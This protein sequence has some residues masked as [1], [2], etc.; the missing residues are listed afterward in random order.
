MYVGDKE[1]ERYAGACDTARITEN[2]ITDV[3]D[4]RLLEQILNRN[5]LNL[6]RK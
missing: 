3:T 5:N 1:H 2:N 4:Q 6:L